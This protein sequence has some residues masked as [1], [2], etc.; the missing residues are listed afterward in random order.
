[1]PARLAPHVT[2]VAVLLA[3]PTNSRSADPP[4]KPVDFDR[5]VKPV[6]AKHCYSCHGPDKQKHGLR[7]D[8]KA[9][10][11]AG[12]DN[13]TV[14]VPGK[15]ADS[16]LVQL[17]SGQDKDRPM[18]PKP[19]EPLAAADIATLKAWIDQGAKW[20][21]DGSTAANPAGWWSLRPVRRPAVPK[22]PSSEFRVPNEIDAFVLAKLAEKA[23]TP[24]PEADRRTLVR[25]LYF[26][27]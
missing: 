5:D 21:D 25:R 2:L 19:K 6:F 24:S 12:G 11:L 15:S 22:V 10:A 14:I 7:L 17:V 20:P 8:R 13:G 3:F 1:M 9:D 23:L 27:L 18:P 26:D 16:L 4:P